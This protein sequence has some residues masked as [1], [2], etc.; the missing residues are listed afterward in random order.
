MGQTG[1]GCKWILA[2]IAGGIADSRKNGIGIREGHQANVNAIMLIE[3]WER[4][5]GYDK[6]VETQ[7]MI[8]SARAGQVE[9]A[10]HHCKG[11]K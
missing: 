5:R 11:N 7:A 9:V 4:L 10:E 2:K 6:W 8:K 3:L 1:N